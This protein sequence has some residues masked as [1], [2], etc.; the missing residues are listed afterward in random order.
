VRIKTKTKLDELEDK[1]KGD[2]VLCRHFI[3]YL[4]IQFKG[5]K[6]HNTLSN[7]IRVLYDE[8]LFVE[9]YHWSDRAG[10]RPFKH[11]EMTNRVLIR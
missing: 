9:V 3:N 11:A 8:E 2:E 6:T 10:K 5:L 7:I 4:N 1:L